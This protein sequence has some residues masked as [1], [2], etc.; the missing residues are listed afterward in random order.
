MA[1]TMK[2]R[3]LLYMESTAAPATATFPDMKMYCSDETIYYNTDYDG[4]T[5]DQ[6]VYF[7][8]PPF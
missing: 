3:L 6:G 8:Y 4:R 2:Q 7:K 1:E 5:Y